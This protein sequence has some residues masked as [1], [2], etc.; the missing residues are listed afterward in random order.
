M[1]FKPASAGFFLVWHQ[2]SGAQ[3]GTWGASLYD[4]D[5]A[6]DLKTTIALVCKVP[7][8]GDHLLGIL[9]SVVG[10]L[11]DPL[12]ADGEDAAL[13]WLVVAD[14]FERR[15][16]ACERATTMAMQI[17]QSG[18]SL[19]QL[20]GRDADAAFLKQR[21]KVLNELC[22]RLAAPRPVRPRKAP[23]KAPEMVLQTGEVYAFQTM[24][25][26]T[27][28]PYR[29][30]GEDEFIG[31]AWGALVV[32]ETGRAFEWLPWCAIASLNIDPASRPTFE[33]ALSAPLITNPLTEGA[34]RFVPR[35]AHAKGLGLELLGK[36]T[37]DPQLVAPHLTSQSIAH[38]IECDWTIA[39]GAFAPALKGLTI[40]CELNALRKT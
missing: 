20:Q 28:H 8:D 1:L 16:I 26:K 2:G 19:E 24:K 22:D 3:M 12:G 37:L 15:S 13:F 38:A 6:A 9:E 4:D 40:R 36:L 34:G 5:D 39:Y 14:Q 25:G 11:D 10:E 21:A 32:L 17:I 18:S 29:L 23:G 33:Q 35:R 27:W 30:P 7:G 31:D